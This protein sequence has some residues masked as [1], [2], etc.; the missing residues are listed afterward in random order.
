[1]K[2]NNVKNLVQSSIFLAF[3]IVIQLIGR[4]FTQINPLLI[5]P[6]ICT[7][8][9]L[10]TYICGLYFGILI[11][12]LIPLFAIPLGA[13]AAPLIPFTPFI[14]IGNIVFS[15]GFAFVMKKGKFGL[16]LGVLLGTLIKVLFLS[17]SAVKLI[18]ILKL[19]ISDESAK[20]ISMAFTAP[21]IIISLLGGAI[22]I[23]IL[24]L[25]K[26]RK[27]NTVNNI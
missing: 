20:M 13:L 23:I 5:G 15:A 8:I 22:A 27:A 10:T 21:Q 16:Y 11:S 4:T 14:V 7:I 3:A 1:M 2:N 17:F 9:L 19:D 6:L 26:K 18:Y 25:L 24:E 12:I